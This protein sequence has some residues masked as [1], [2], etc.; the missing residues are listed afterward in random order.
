MGNELKAPMP[1]FGGKSRVA[2]DVWRRFGDVPNYVEPFYGSGAVLLGRPHPPKI[3][4]VNDRDGFIANFWRAMKADPVAVAD[5]ANWPVNEMDKTARHVWLVQQ[6]EKM[7]KRLEVDPEYFDAK[8]AGWWCWGQCLWIG[9]GWCS[10]K[11]GWAVQDGALVRADG[12]EV[13][14]QLP[15]MSGVGVIRQIPH[16]RNAGLGVMKK[17]PHLSN[18][19]LGVVKKRPHLSA[20]QGVTR[21]IPHLR[22][23]G[24]GVT[25]QV[26]ILGSTGVG[27]CR[28]VPHISSAGQGVT[29]APDTIGGDRREFLIDWFQKLAARLENVRVCCGDWSRIVTPAVTYRLGITGVFLDPPYSTES[30][31]CEGV[32]SHD[33][34][35]VAHDVA[36]WCRANG[37]NRMMRIALCGYEGEHKMPGWTEH[38][39]KAAGGYGVQGEGRGRSNSGRER[40]WFSPHCL[41]EGEAPI[42]QKDRVGAFLKRLR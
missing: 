14:K 5:A 6:R 12:G 17:R 37:T 40:I 13:T 42:T 26:P 9:A 16:Q 27:V 7:T 22:S 18:T 39:W 41:K 23:T 19:G 8:I 29:V 33:D 35:S 38:A 25:R 3:E 30:D 28:Q 11:G 10:G 15:H 31:R 2:E 32:Y 4:T 21:Q 36:E 1:Y 24:L 20:G 34:M